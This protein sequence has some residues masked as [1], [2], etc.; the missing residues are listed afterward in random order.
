MLRPPGRLDGDVGGHGRPGRACPRCPRA[1][2]DGWRDRVHVATTVE[3]AVAGADLVQENGPERPETKAALIAAADAAA[4]A[5]VLI[6]SSSSGTLPSVLVAAAAHHPG[7]VVVGH[8]FNPVYLMPLVEVVGAPTTPA[9]TLQR[10]RDTY[11][12][13]GKRP[14]VLTDEVPGY[15]ANRLQ[16]ALWREAYSLVERGVVTVEDVDTAIAHGPGLRWALLGPIA[17]QHLS[18]GAG[19]LAH[20]LEH[21][22]PPTQRWMD[23]LGAPRLTPGLAARLVAGVEAELRG[24]TP[25][26]SPVSVTGAWSHCCCSRTTSRRSRDLHLPHRR[27]HRVGD[28]HARSRR[29]GRPRPPVAGR[30]ADG[31]VGRLLQGGEEPH[32]HGRRPR[33]GLPRAG[34]GSRGLHRR[35][36]HQHGARR[37]EQ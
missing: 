18:G 1:R 26:G 34:D 3:D 7:R 25:S 6:A 8:P 4:P 15:L 10:A 12:A 2:V 27:R 23:D 31:R 22:G 28:R 17:N 11:L 30:R 36:P 5:D 37:A 13:L 14:V 32:A 29:E 33:P 24:A 9:R 35:C 21:L 16:A 19:G 20:V